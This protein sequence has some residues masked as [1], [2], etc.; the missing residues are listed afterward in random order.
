M[1]P[2]DFEKNP[3]TVTE[4]AVPGLLIETIDSLLLAS[5]RERAFVAN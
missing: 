2:I 3:A 4:D 1:A 5:K